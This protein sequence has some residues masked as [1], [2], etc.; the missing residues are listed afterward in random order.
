MA[1]PYATDDLANYLGIGKQSVFGTGVTPTLF[2]PYTGDVSIE[3]GMEGEDVW[4]GG[5]GPFLN[6][7]VKTKHKPNGSFTMPVRPAS[8]AKLAA[9]FLG[10]DVSAAASSLFDHTASPLQ[11]PTPLTIEW[12]QGADLIERVAGCQLTKMTLSS[13]EANGELTCDVSWAGAVPTVGTAATP[14]YETGQHA[15]TPGGAFRPSDAVYK[16]DNAT[17]S[18]VVGWELAM[19]WGVD[20]DIFTS[21]WKRAAFTKLKFTAGLKVRLLELDMAEYKSVNYGASGATATVADYLEGTSSSWQV[22][23]DNALASTNSRKLTVNCPLVQ[24][25]GAPRKIGAP[26]GTSILEVTGVVHY[27]GSDIVTLVSRNADTAAYV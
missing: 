17:I 13:P 23:Y 15:L 6:R 20:E 14:S 19:D 27:L 22:V 7:T 16:L 11:L 9:Y 24:W 1:G 21:S 3:H 12:A 10:K 5:S 18:N 4:E 25:T 2:V 26:G 8:F